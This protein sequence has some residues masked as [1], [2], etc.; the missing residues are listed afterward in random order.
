MVAGTTKRFLHG[1]RLGAVVDRRVVHDDVVDRALDVAVADAHAGRRVA[2]G[3]EVD[4]QDAVIELGERRAQVHRRRGLA[5][6]TL[7]VRDRDDERELDSGHRPRPAPGSRRG[8]RAA[9][10]GSAPGTGSA[11]VRTGSGDVWTSRPVR[12][13]RR[14]PHRRPGRERRRPSRPGLSRLVAEFHVVLP[15]LRRGRTGRSPSA[16]PAPATLAFTRGAFLIWASASSDA[17][18][19]LP[20]GRVGRTYRARHRT[21]DFSSH[22]GMLTVRGRR[23]VLPAHENTTDAENFG[24]MFHVKHETGRWVPGPLP[25]RRT[26]FH[27]KHHHSGRFPVDRPRA[28]IRSGAA[29]ALRIVAKCASPCTWMAAGPNPSSAGARKRPPIWVRVRRLAHDEDSADCDQ[30][31]GDL[32][33]SGRGGEAPGGRQLEALS[34]LRV[35]ADVLRPP[36]E[37]LDPVVG[38]D[39]PDRLGEKHAPAP[40]CFD[41]HA[42]GVRPRQRQHQAGNAATGAEVDEVRRAIAPSASSAAA[43]NPSAWSRWASTGP[44]P[45]KPALRASSRIGRRA[46]RGAL[47]GHRPREL[48]QQSSRGKD[49]HPTPGVFALGSRVDTVD[50]G[51]WCRGQPCGRPHPSAP[52]PALRRFP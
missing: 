15:L 30:S 3:I 43:A 28:G 50:V 44:G 26:M 34:I 27:V 42:P 36:F 20:T 25:G 24:A 5:D 39:A 1:R 21:D 22:G 45:R 41:Q 37:D 32:R 14:R 19:R 18:S 47:I 38:A 4:D 48:R 49:Y 51:R 2:L 23:I 9:E 46:S 7:L 52:S 12:S 17:I 16:K 29:V 33:G 40:A 35:T 11:R 8:L 6:P 13:G 31:G 10:P